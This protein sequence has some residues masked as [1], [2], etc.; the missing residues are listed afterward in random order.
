MNYESVHSAHLLQ[1]IIKV[2]TKKCNPT[3]ARD[4]K[5]RN[6][7]PRELRFMT[8]DVIANVGLK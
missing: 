2:Y 8:L 3:K 5:K 7:V 4:K 6:V 1:Q